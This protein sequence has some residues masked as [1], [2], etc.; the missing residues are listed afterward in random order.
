MNTIDLV[1]TGRLYAG[2]CDRP[3]PLFQN[4]QHAVY[5]LGIPDLTS[6]HCNI[7]LIVD[8]EEAILVDPGEKS[9]FELVMKRV[10]QILPPEK[11]SALIISHQ[12]PDVAGSMTDWLMFNPL[13]KVIT[14]IRTN[15]LLQYYGKHSY[16]FYNV[17]DNLTW[18]FESGRQLKFTESPFLHFAGAFTTYDVASRFL[19]TGDI[20]SSIGMEWKLVVD[21]FEKHKMKLTLFHLDYMAS[22]IAA[23][24][25]LNR[26]RD[27]AI[28]AIL[29]QHGS[30][31]PK[32]FIHHAMTY[33]RGLKCGL[34][35]IYPELFEGLI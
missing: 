1:E 33:L 9:S 11:I 4:Q 22:G 29:P 5:W 35:L 34:D 12:D 18:R 32:K 26:I 21:D 8:G 6:F 15:L 25:Y 13:I 16:S 7:Y 2:D 17:N 31:I 27:L 14:T 23:R 10:S 19:F 24:G 3:T 28:H 20:W 30:I